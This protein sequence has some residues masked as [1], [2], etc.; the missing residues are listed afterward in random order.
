MAEENKENSKKKKNK[1]D[2]KKLEV[3]TR[4]PWK[5]M[6]ID[7]KIKITKEEKKKKAAG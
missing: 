3:F 7:D 4:S 6:E 5:Y 1:E 2:K